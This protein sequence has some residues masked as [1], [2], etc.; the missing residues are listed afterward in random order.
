[1]GRRSLDISKL[2]QSL[3]GPGRDTRTWVSIAFANG[4]SYFDAAHGVFVDVTLAPS[5]QQMTARV[6]SNYAGARFGF[7]AKI[8]IDDEIVVAIPNGDPAEGAVVV[9]RL[10]SAADIPP[11]DGATNVDEVMLVVEKDKSFRLRCSGGGKIEIDA[12]ADV[13]ITTTGDA[14]VIAGGTIRLGA[15]T[16]VAPMDGVVHGT[17]IDTFTGATYFALGNAS[18]KVLAK[19]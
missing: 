5:G 6:P 18:T 8:H 11:A 10:W 15:N 12:E 19:K 17:G 14:N 2:G 4:E 3:S 7:Y 16:L 9:G 13:T 1:M